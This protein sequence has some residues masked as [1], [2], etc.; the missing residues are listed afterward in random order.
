M[1]PELF[2]I[3]FIHVTIKSYGLMMVIG[4]LF[5]VALMRRLAVRLGEDPED[6]TNVALYALIAGVI[7]ARLFY[8]IHYFDT[9]KGRLL[10]IFAIWNGGLEF[11]GGVILAIIVTITYLLRRK[12]SPARYMDMLVV[13]LMLGLAFGRIGCFLNGCC[14]G[15]ATDSVCAVHFPYGSFP[16][17]SQVFPDEKRNRPEPL[18]QLPDEFY[19]YESEDGET[20]FQADRSQQHK[21]NLK[22]RDLLT[23]EQ[24]KLI[25]GEFRALGIHPT[26]LYSTTNALIL[27]LLLY[28]FW[29]RNSLVR[30]GYTFSLMF[31]LY[32]SSRFVLEMFRDDN[33]FESAWWVLY[34]GATVSQNLGIYMIAIG[35]ILMAILSKSRPAKVKAT[36]QKETKKPKPKRKAKKAKIF[37]PIV[38]K[39]GTVDVKKADTETAADTEMI[40]ALVE[41]KPAEEEAASDFDEAEPEEV[42]MIDQ[43]EVQI[44]QPEQDAAVYTAGLTELAEQTV[45]DAAGSETAPVV[46]VE[47]DE[48]DKEAYTAALKEAK[49]H[50]DSER[51][52]TINEPNPAESLRKA[53]GHLIKA[54][55]RSKK[56]TG[57][58][59]SLD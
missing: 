10:S 46:V 11:L 2:E 34:K 28:L 36:A 45:K 53:K 6:I 22:P 19:G 18:M 7:G 21:A 56:K 44:E 1:I 29:R 55:K 39:V 59:P 35:I 49:Q 13:G 33:P 25:S 32:G 24:Q 41:T 54:K 26:Q 16:Y 38:A 15:A 3:P 27:C 43:P 51:G 47:Q 20:W 17:Q 12:L 14:F 37:E 42:I 4:F 50:A 23:E 31:I 30:P 58:K 5:A 40:N 57:D 8:V 52:D 48:P 9:F